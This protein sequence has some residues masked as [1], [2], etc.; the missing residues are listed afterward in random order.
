M[1]THPT[2]SYHL[3]QAQ[4]AELHR[5]AERAHMARAMSQARRTRT[6]RSHRV[7]ALPAVMGRRMLTVLGGSS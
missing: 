5:Q 6:S 1:Y 4:I 2:I 3:A 7:R